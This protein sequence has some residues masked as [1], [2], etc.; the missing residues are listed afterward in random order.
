MI[1]NYKLPK[2]LNEINFFKKEE[3]GC[4]LYSFSKKNEIVIVCKLEYFNIEK[5]FCIDNKTANIIKNLE[6]IEKIELKNDKIIVKSAKGNYTGKTF[7]DVLPHI[8][9]ANNNENKVEIEAKRIKI[10]KDF[11]SQSKTKPVLC[12][13]SINSLGDIAATDGFTVFY[14]ENND[15]VL[16]NENKAKSIIM[17]K[18]FAD[19]ILKDF[20]DDEKIEL[21]FDNNKCMVQKE[22]IIYISSLI[23]GIYPNIKGIFSSYVPD[24]SAEYDLKELKE[25]L[26]F[27]NELGKTIQGN[28]YCD[29]INEKLEIVGEDKFEC[30]LNCKC[31]DNVDF[32]VDYLYLNK[33]I[34]NIEDDKLSIKHQSENR[35][36]PI[37]IKTENNNK[38]ILLPIRKI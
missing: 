22:N 16:K 21:F 17:S 12:G 1:E 3:K 9:L 25:K 36:K 7:E 38:F 6:P 5:D 15:N 26:I 33:I 29:F 35:L 13:I 31:Y 8:N 37:F 11:V 23:D 10:A 28:V 20:K 24:I 30:V 19:F 4:T 32:R 2:N 18:E 27:A 14:Y 34:R